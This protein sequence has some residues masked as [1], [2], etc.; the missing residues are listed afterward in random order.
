LSR[1]S[2]RSVSSSAIASCEA[3]TLLTDG[4]AVL[5]AAAGEDDAKVKEARAA[6]INFAAH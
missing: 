6:L 2:A 5:A 3:R 4:V 1:P